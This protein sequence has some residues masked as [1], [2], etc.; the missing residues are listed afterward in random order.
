MSQEKLKAI[1]AENLEIPV[2]EVTDTLAYGVAETW[3][4]IAHMALIAAI[5]GAFDIMIETDDVIDM[6]SFAKA[7]EIVRKYGVEA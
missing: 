6:S 1:F 3:D 4:S 7:R 5:E 2:T